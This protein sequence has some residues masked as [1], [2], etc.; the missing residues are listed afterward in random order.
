M[1]PKS[2]EK[3]KTRA[4]MIHLNDFDYKRT[5]AAADFCGLQTGPWLR[6]HLLKILKKVE[7]NGE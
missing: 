4:V 3:K 1:E 7:A 2:P 6:M 5:V